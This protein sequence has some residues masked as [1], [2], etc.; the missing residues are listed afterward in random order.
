MK[1]TI[2][3]RHVDTSAAFHTKVEEDLLQFNMTHHI[4][5]VE[6]TVILSKENNHFACHVTLHLKKNMTLRCYGQGQEA[7]H[8]FDNT[9]SLLTTRLRR[10]KKRIADYHKQRDNH[11]QIAETLPYFVL[12]GQEVE[13]KEQ[14]EHAAAIIAEHKKEIP[15]LTVGDAVMHLDLSN[16]NALVFRNK[17]HGKINFIY[18]RS[19]GN[20]GWVDVVN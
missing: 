2:T 4:D 17:N 9:L 14:E 1:L 10:H 5:P 7:Y 6:A 8:C 18:R 15:S 12:N 13:E 16:E 11:E 20:I 19:D 3:G